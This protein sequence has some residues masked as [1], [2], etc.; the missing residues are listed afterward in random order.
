M[1]K[2]IVFSPKIAKNKEIR[3]I[4]YRF[5]TLIGLHVDDKLPWLCFVKNILDN[6]GLIEF[7]SKV[8][9]IFKDQ[10]LQTG[11]I[12]SRN[13]VCMSFS[14]QC[15]LHSEAHNIAYA[16]NNTCNL[17]RVNSRINYT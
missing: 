17:K 11:T 6:W 15:E 8:E 7:A 1:Y 14:I 9:E 12:K 3:N 5:F 13:H 10:F 16:L 4:T 2:Y